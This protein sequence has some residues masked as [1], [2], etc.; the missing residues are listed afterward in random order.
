[1]CFPEEVLKLDAFITEISRK[2]API[3]EP[4]GPPGEPGIPGPKGSP[5]V[6]GPQGPVGPRGRPGRPGYPGEQ[7]RF[8][9]VKTIQSKGFA[10]VKAQ[11][12]ESLLLIRTLI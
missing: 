12:N 7:G 5:G 1:M 11:E 3:E 10:F 4:E 9:E 8:G 6:R 2:P